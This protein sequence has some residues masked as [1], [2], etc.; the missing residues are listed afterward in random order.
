MSLANSANPNKL[1][2]AQLQKEF[3]KLAQ[4]TLQELRQHC[5]T[6]AAEEGI[7]EEEALKIGFADFQK[8]LE[9]LKTTK[10]QIEKATSS[11]KSKAAQSRPTRRW[12][13]V[14]GTCE[15]ARH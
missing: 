14:L 2:K 11:I 1:D 3:D 15:C 6:Y 8:H 9:S 4:E 7:S 12:R 5:Y 10:S 13:G